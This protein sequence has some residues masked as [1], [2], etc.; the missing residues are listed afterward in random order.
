MPRERILAIVRSFV[1]KSLDGEILIGQRVREFVNQGHVAHIDGRPVGNE[2]LLSFEIVKGRGLFGQQ[3]D[4]GLLQIEI[5]RREPEL[6]QR[7]FFRANLIRLDGVHFD[8]LLD[9][10]IY[11]VAGDQGERKLFP[12]AEAP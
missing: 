1:E 6:L 5:R 9:V 3:V 11:L 10:S 12:D 4:G 8:L 7:G 2:K